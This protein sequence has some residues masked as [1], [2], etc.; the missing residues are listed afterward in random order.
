M[1]SLGTAAG[2]AGCALGRHAEPADAAARSGE[3]AHLEGRKLG[4]A[5]HA[6]VL[7]LAAD[8]AAKGVHK[9]GA[10]GALLQVAC[11]AGRGTREAI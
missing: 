6:L 5:V 7:V 10:A 1:Q 11:R 8:E 9:H 3:A 4:Q 2:Q